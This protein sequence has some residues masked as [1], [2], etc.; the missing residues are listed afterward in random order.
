M[1]ET[2][3]EP[4]RSAGQ[5]LHLARAREKQGQLVESLAVYD[6]LREITPRSSSG[7]ALKQVRRLAELHG[8]SIHVE[9]VEGESTE[10]TVFLPFLD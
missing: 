4:S 10:F 8:G 9:S 5:W 3:P 7:E 2:I 1:I 6:R